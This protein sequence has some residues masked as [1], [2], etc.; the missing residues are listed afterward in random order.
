MRPGKTE[1]NQIDYVV[2]SKK[3]ESGIAGVRTYRWV[4]A[5]TDHYTKKRNI[6]EERKM[7]TI[8]T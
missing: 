2:I 4:N 3:H 8:K 6:N 1:R 5:S 7:D